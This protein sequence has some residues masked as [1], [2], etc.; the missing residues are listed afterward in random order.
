M[1]NWDSIVYSILSS[2]PDSR[3]AFI[4]IKVTSYV[5]SVYCKVCVGFFSFSFVCSSVTVCIFLQA[6]LMGK[7]FQ[8]FA[9]AKFSGCCGSLL[10]LRGSSFV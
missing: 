8:V 10:G 3:F 2:L 5:V 1:E 4:G 7:L 9:T 6:S